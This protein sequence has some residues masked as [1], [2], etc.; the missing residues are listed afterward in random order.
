[1]IARHKDYLWRAVDQNGN[2]LDILVQSRRNKKAAKRFFRK[3]LKGV[4][5]PSLLLFCDLFPSYNSAIIHT[6]MAKLTIPGGHTF[7]LTRETG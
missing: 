6:P 2:V 7:I 3:L 1:M 4:N 5:I